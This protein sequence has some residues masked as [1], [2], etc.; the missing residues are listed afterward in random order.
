MFKNMG[1]NIPGENFWVG[2]FRVGIFQGEFDGREF[3]GGSF[4]DTLESM[5]ESIPSLKTLQNTYV[6]E[7]S[8]WFSHTCFESI[9]SCCSRYHTISIT[10]RSLQD[11]NLKFHS[12]LFFCFYLIFPLC[13]I[14]NK[15]NLT[16]VMKL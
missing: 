3:S 15:H 2:I 11:T 6:T 14:A 13:W 12:H 16:Y 9:K 8:R 4:P 10:K 5:L 7:T 1:E